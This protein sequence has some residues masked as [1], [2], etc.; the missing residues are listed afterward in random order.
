MN[1]DTNRVAEYRELASSSDGHLW[2]ASNAEEIYRL[3]NGKGDIPGTETITFIAPQEV[4]ADKTP[5]YIRVVVADR[6]EKSNPKRVRWTAGGNLISYAGNVH[7]QT[8]DLVTAKIFFNS[9]ISTPHAQCMCID[10]KDFY[11]GTIL[12]EPEY[13]RIP[14]Y[15]I[16][17]EVMDEY[18]LHDKLSNGFVYARVNKGMYGLPQAG[19]LAWE[20]LRD[21]LQ[22]FGYVPCSHTPGLWKHT[23]SSL[24]FTLVVDDFCVRYTNK[25]DAQQLVAA[26]QH[27][28]TYKA[29]VD[30]EG[31]RYVGLT[32]DWHYKT[33]YVDISMP[34]Y[35]ERALQRFGHPTPDKLVHS[36]SKYTSPNYGARIQY[37]PDPDSSQPV[38][39]KQRKR[40]QEVLGTLLYY[41]RAV[42]CCIL[43][44][45]GT[46]AT[47][48]A[49]PTADTLTA[50]TH[51]LNYCASNPEATVRYTRSDMILHIES[52]ASYLSQPKARSRAAGYFY[53]SDKTIDIA[54]KPRFNGNVHIHCQI[55]KEVLSSAAESELGALFYNGKDGCPIRVCLEELGHPQPPTILVTD[56]S[57]AIGIAKDACKQKRSKAMDMR[58]YWV[59]DRVRQGQYEVVWRPGTTNEADYFTK[60]HPADYHQQMREH[61]LQPGQVT[62]HVANLMYCTY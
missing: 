4:P 22:P 25:R 49:R 55:M 18:D 26:L 50:V 7:T 62:V 12:P 10:L 14:R 56:N 58:Y 46:I 3:A 57:T 53:L 35:V 15:M 40:I 38:D 24:Q 8:A 17:D 20:K 30:W 44:A 23:Q 1:P 59:R 51:L 29:S 61:Y 6:P 47:Q 36:P 41:A 13:V 32:L 54:T 45:L 48:Q 11:L 5:T 28:G 43:E 42:D 2:A 34:G 33:G 19:R 16:P 37:A 27:N 21:H 31:T 60:A 39:D 52:D 9:I